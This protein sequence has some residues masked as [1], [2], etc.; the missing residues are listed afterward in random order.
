MRGGGVILSQ[1]HWQQF[2]IALPLAPAGQFHQHCKARF[3]RGSTSSITLHKLWY[4]T[5]PTPADSMSGWIWTQRNLLPGLHLRWVRALLRAWLR[6]L[7]LTGA[8]P[9]V[10]TARAAQ[11]LSRSIRQHHVADVLPNALHQKWLKHTHPGCCLHTRPN[12]SVLS[13]TSQGS[14]YQA[15]K[16]T[17]HQQCAPGTSTA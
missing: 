14:S 17:G 5:H 11:R 13:H 9:A 4:A 3:R 8:G 10:H 12:H 16:A 7:G 6:W 1:G 2:A 15:I